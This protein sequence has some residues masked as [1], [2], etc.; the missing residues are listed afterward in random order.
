MKKMGGRS[1]EEV[2]QI[3]RAI[4][5]QASD[6]EKLQYLVVRLQEMLRQEVLKQELPKEEPYR[7]TKIVRHPEDP[8]DKIMLA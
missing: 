8:Y 5:N 7:S 2:R 6:P 3:C 1:N 4:N